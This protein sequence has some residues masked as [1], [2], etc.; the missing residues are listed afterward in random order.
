M[1]LWPTL[2]ITFFLKEDLHSSLEEMKYLTF[3]QLRAPSVAE[4]RV[5]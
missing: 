5:N 1:R 2:M 3:V 4:A